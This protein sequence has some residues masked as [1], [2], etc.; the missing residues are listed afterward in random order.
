MTLVS[1][2]LGSALGLIKADAVRKGYADRVF[3]AILTAGFWIK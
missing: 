1:D 2:P 3:E